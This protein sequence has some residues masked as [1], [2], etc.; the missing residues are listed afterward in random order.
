[1]TTPIFLALG[2]PL[3]SPLNETLGQAAQTMGGAMNLPE[4]R[5]ATF[6][7]GLTAEE[8]RAFE[9]PARFRVYRGETLIVISLS[10]ARYSFDL[11]WSPVT[12]TLTGEPP[13]EGVQ[14]DVHMLFTFIL[15]DDALVVRGLRQATISPEVGKAINRAQRELHTIAQI[16]HQDVAN[17]MSRIFD[18]HPDGLPDGMFH[19]ICNL[20]D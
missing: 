7:P 16:R 6:L 10:F 8:I 5:I 19:A 9:G 14:A 13:F 11:V 17:E 15:V 2:A 12:A 20:G 1:M 3:P 18:A 4:Q